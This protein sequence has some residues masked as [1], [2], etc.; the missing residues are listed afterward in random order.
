MR[1]LMLV[2]LS[3]LAGCGGGSRVTQRQLFSQAIGS[4][5]TQAPASA[6]PTVWLTNEDDSECDRVEGEPKPRRAVS[7]EEALA[8]E[9]FSNHVVTSRWGRVIEGHRHNYARDLKADTRKPIS[10]VIGAKQEAVTVMEDL[11]FL[12]EAKKRNADKVLV[13]QVL[14]AASSG[15]MVHFRLSDARTG[16]VEASKTLQVVGSTVQDRSDR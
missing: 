5:L 1:L 8:Y 10:V 15:V 6:A 16:L 7:D 13:F 12:D 14:G 3:A 9:V 2:V 11:C 4:F